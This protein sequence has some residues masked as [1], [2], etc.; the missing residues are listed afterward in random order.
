MHAD[1]DMQ[2]WQCG[3][4]SM[5]MW[6]CLNKDVAMLPYICGNASTHTEHFHALADIDIPRAKHSWLSD[7]LGQVDDDTG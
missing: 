3:H 6:P 5:E 7:C 2:P 4:A 1:V